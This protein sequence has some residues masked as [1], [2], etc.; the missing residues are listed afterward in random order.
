MPCRRRNATLAQL[1]S[2]ADE[3]STRYGLG[4]ILDE[5][6]DH[7]PLRA[8]GRGR[9][10]NLGVKFLLP[11]TSSRCSESGQVLSEFV[12]LIDRETVADL[13]P[14]RDIGIDDPSTSIRTIF[15]L[16]HCQPGLR[17]L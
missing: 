2:V 7:D 9:I 5:A 15:R 16:I 11:A 14:S 8:V 3:T 17:P 1:R 12:A 4:A 6:I 10:G 13:I